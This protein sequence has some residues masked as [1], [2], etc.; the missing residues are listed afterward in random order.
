MREYI[1][2]RHNVS[3]LLYHFV[4]P[5]K[6][7]NVV[8]SKEVDE[9]LKR[10]CLEI[11]KRY[12][13]HFLEIGT[14]KNHVHFLIQSIPKNSPTRII[15]IL[16]SL[17]AREIFKTMPEVKKILWGSEFWTDGYFVNTV[18]YKGSEDT[19]RKYVREQG[20]GK[21]YKALHKDIQLSLFDT[22]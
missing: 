16:K 11:G 4:C 5:A 1:H 8:L 21:E 15:R 2:K 14:D 6:Y 19:V 12:E 22:P 3:V 9:E 7:R 18:G 17:T 10:I 20:T 13:L